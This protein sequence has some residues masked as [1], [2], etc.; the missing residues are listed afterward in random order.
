MSKRPRTEAPGSGV[1]RTPVVEFSPVLNTPSNL[2][3]LSPQSQTLSSLPSGVASVESTGGRI[4]TTPYGQPGQYL[5]VD[6][7]NKLAWV[8][9]TSGGGTV[10]AVT[11][12]GSANGISL[13]TVPPG[14]ISTYGSV[15]IQGNI[16]GLDVDQ[17][18]TGNASF[19]VNEYLRGNGTAPIVTSPYVPVGDISG[20]I[21]ISQGGTGIDLTPSTYGFLRYAPLS[22]T[23]VT[24]QLI[25]VTQ[26][27]TP[28]PIPVSV[29]GTGRT[30]FASGQYL[31]GNGTGSVTTQSGVPS[32]NITGLP[33]TVADGGTGIT[34]YGN[35]TFLTGAGSI[36]YEQ[37]PPIR[38]D[39]G[40]T[41][42][43][44]A[45]QAL[46]NL[47]AAASGA[48]VDITS[49]GGLTSPLP[50]IAGGVPVG[51]VFLWMGT[52]FPTGYLE[53]DGS[54]ID[55][56][57]YGDLYAVIGDRYGVA[58]LS[59]NFLLPDCRGRF[60]RFTSGT[61]GMDP[62]AAQRVNDPGESGSASNAPPYGG[63]TVGS[64]QTES[65]IPHQHS[66]TYG[67]TQGDIDAPNVPGT[68]T[69][70][71]SGAGPRVASADNTVFTAAGVTN[72]EGNQETRPVN[73][74]MTAIIKALL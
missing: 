55:R 35:G 49:L 43:T 22:S 18:G 11:A 7:D 24:T 32:S 42:A 27:I 45:P 4:Q 5:S 23:P 63:N 19:P 71:T 53:C 3:G 33:W 39:Q 67:R 38:I 54:S 44:N 30:S 13:V 37:S 25:D 9:P 62:G 47:G 74:Y 26:D 28:V 72:F 29:G 31:K 56:G 58:T 65:I 8:D 64:L 73:I 52:V 61:S 70:G 36:I 68:L 6:T 34:S 59:N 57:V 21:P 60:P 16:S 12:T 66:I 15:E 40:G 20:T 1:N 51:A 10:L 69:G 14:G 46:F 48:N 50:A 41:D 2:P 17:G